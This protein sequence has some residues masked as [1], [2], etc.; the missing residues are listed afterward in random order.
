MGSKLIL[1]EVGVC[2]DSTTNKKV[3]ARQVAVAATRG[4]LVQILLIAD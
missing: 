2:P 3:P 4:D 1:A